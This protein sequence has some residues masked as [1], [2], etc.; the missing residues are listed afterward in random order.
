VCG[1]LCQKLL[2][3][4]LILILEEECSDDSSSNKEGPPCF[5]EEVTDCSV[6]KLPVKW[7]GRDWL[8]TTLRRSPNLTPLNDPSFGNTSK[9]LCMCHR[10]VP[11]CRNFLG[12]YELK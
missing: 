4:F 6:L 12:G 2:A 5:H 7:F 1:V 11:V 3:E 8:I 10:W 9:M